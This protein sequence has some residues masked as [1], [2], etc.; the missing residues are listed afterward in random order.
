VDAQNNIQIKNKVIAKISRREVAEK[1]LQPAPP[2]LLAELVAQ[3]QITE[4]QANLAQHIPMADDLTAEADSG[5]HTDNRPLVSLLPAIIALRDELQAQQ[6]FARPVRVGAAGG[7]GTPAAALAAFMMGAAYI[8]TGS[9]NQACLEAGASDHSKALL[10]QADMADVMM[11]PAADMFE[12]G[13]KL[14]VLKRGTFF[15]M[16]AQKLYEL[17]QTYDGLDAIPLDERKKLEERVFK[18][19]LDSIWADTAAYFAKRDPD[20]ITRAENNPKRK[21]AL[22]FRW[23]LGLSSRWSNVGEKGRE[24]DY[25]IWCGPSMGAFN[26]WVQGSYLAEPRNRRATDVAH[27]IMTGAAVMYRLQHLRLLGLQLPSFYSHYCPQPL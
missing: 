25:Q 21:M 11:A 2:R 27:H 9:V 13:V 22:V 1:F 12:M 17:Y 10:A 24:V 4:L 16:R 5:G 15:P 19:S 20:Q 3:N 14:Q 18:R 23:Y 7:I 6:R 26:A 8:V